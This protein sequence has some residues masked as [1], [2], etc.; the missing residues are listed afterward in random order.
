MDQR[1]LAGAVRTNDRVQLALG[2]V[3]AD[4][5]DRQHAAEAALQAADAQSHV[6]RHR[7]ARPERPSGANSTTASSTT[8]MASGQWIVCSAIA[9]SAIS[10]TAAPTAPP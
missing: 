10:S 2:E 7:R 1:R 5:V 8:P 9:S 6:R 4:I 3:E